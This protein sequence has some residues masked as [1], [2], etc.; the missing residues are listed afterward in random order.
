MSVESA[1]NGQR[2][3][4]RNVSFNTITGDKF[5]YRT[6][7]ERSADGVNTTEK[8]RRLKL[9]WNKKNDSEVLINKI[10]F[11]FFLSSASFK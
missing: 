1:V 7:I 3:A 9:S 6:G 5:A 11:S 10:P 4:T 2:K 8:E